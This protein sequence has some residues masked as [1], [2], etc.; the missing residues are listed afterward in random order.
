MK[1]CLKTFGIKKQTV[2]AFGINRLIEMTIN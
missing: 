2:D 1:K